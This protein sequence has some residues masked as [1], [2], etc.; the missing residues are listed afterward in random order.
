MAILCCNVPEDSTEAVMKVFRDI[1]PKL[2]LPANPV[3]ENFSPDKIKG[4]LM[5]VHLKACV[6][7]V[8]GKTFKDAYK[9]LTEKRV[10]YTLAVWRSEPPLSGGLWENSF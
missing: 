3:F 5:K 1:A 2:N 6:L 4:Y 10:Y 8:D 7:L 9:N